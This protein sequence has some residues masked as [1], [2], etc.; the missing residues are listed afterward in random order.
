M[1][2]PSVVH[3]RSLKQEQRVPSSNS[4]QRFPHFLVRFPDST[5]LT[6]YTD[7][8]VSLTGDRKRAR[9]FRDRQTAESI[10]TILHGEVIEVRQQ[11]EPAFRCTG[12]QLECA[13]I[14]TEIAGAQFVGIFPAIPGH[15]PLVL[16]NSKFSGSTLGIPLPE[17]SASAVRAILAKSDAAFGA[18]R[19]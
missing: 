15:V 8:G 18:V 7:E 17:I 16:F 9:I 14:L 13:R 2:A 12:T 11:K 5:Y 1:A 4:S 10:A 3:A 19:P 6:A